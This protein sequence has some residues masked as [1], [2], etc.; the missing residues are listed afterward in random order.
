M[1]QFWLHLIVASTIPLKGNL[2]PGERNPPKK[3]PKQRQRRDPLKKTQRRDPSL[4]DGWMC[5]GCHPCRL[6]QHNSD[7]QCMEWWIL[8]MLQ[9]SINSRP[10]LK[11]MICITLMLHFT[12]WGMPQ[13]N[14][15]PAVTWEKTRWSWH[16]LSFSYGHT[17]S[18]LTAW[19][20]RCCLMTK[21]NSILAMHKWA[22]VHAK[23]SAKMQCN[24]IACNVMW[25]RTN[26]V[27][28]RRVRCGEK[29]LH[30]SIS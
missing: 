18:T 5:S 24:L 19:T 8:P 4:Q 12:A 11:Y 22:Q 17:K 10:A 3:Y 14:V 9:E 27:L 21:M 28:S 2:K 25:W 15:S 30:W 13:V 16:C 23:H 6:Q 20:G 1:T 7:E 26:T 29:K